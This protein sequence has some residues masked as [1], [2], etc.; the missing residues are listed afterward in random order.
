MNRVTA[1]PG[2]V[3]VVLMDLSP[4][5]RDIIGEIVA[6]EADM[7]VVAQLSDTA[8]LLSVIREPGAE[9]VIIGCDPTTSPGLIAEMLGVA[10]RLKVI[11]LETDRHE[12]TLHEL[13]LGSTTIPNPSVDN[14]IAAIRTVV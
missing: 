13:K 5:L 11:C 3:R 4:L 9:V 14:L 8:R 2:R 7:T 10:P 1:P 12:A 6:L